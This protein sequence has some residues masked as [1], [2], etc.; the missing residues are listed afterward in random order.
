[1]HCKF[2]YKPRVR[3]FKAVLRTDRHSRP[4]TSFRHRWWTATSIFS[5]SVEMDSNYEKAYWIPVC[6]Q[7]ERATQTCTCG[8]W[9]KGRI[10]NFPF[11]SKLLPELAVRISGILNCS[12]Y[13]SLSTFPKKIL[14]PSKFAFPE[15]SAYVC[16]IKLNK[17]I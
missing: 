10:Q 4:Y 13:C 6:V 17:L 16:I 15:N 11:L 9:N 3:M 2:L 8:M 12:S 7:T 1:M 5:R 14:K